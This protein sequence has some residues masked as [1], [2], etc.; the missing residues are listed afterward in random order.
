MAQLNLRI[1]DKLMEEAA[2][3]FEEIGM[4]LSTGIKIYLK[5][6][7]REQAIPFTLSLPQN[8]YA[9]SVGEFERGDFKTASSSEELLRDLEDTNKP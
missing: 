7:V 4:D 3:F 9:K 8:D 1:D 6:V 5:K 2:K